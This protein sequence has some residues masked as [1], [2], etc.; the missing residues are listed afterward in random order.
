MAVDL[1]AAQPAAPAPFNVQEARRVIDAPSVSP[2]AFGATAQMAP[3]TAAGLELIK[4]VL[5]L[6]A[7]AIVLL[8]VVLSVTEYRGFSRTNEV[9]DGAVAE[10]ASTP[11]ATDAD[12]FK[13]L[14]AQMRLAQVDP[15][16]TLSPGELVGAKADLNQLASAAATTPGQRAA[17]A[18]CIPLPPASTATRG[19]IVDKC[20]ATIAQ[21]GA[22]QTAAGDRVKLLE[23][24]QKQSDDERQAFRTFWMQVAQLILMNLF[25]PV[26]TALL[27]YIFGTQR[28]GGG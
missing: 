11:D 19:E 26:I 3:L 18:P 23:E 6:T 22:S 28:A 17:L 7:A 20:V 14:S 5:Y 4:L 13:R 10:A 2:P 25:F 21:L 12:R 27:G 24:L 9:L 1:S 15:A 8:V 16:W